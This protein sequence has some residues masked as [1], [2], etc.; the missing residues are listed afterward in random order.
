MLFFSVATLANQVFTRSARSVWL[1]LI[2]I[3]HR[4]VQA[5]STFTAFTDVYGIVWFGW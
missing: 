1:D 5:D 3:E 2:D 4:P